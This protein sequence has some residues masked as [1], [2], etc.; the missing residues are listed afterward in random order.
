MRVTFDTN[1]YVSAFEFGGV[2]MKLLDM[3]KDGVLDVAVSPAILAET[4]RVLRGK[5]NWPESALENVKSILESYT[6][7]V[8]PT[9]AISAVQDDPD[10]NRILECAKASGS[11]AIITR[12][13]H[14][15]RLGRYEGIAM[16]TVA[17]FLRG[18][19]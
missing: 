8:T 2:C 9:E 17:D 11:D 15:L 7:M 1:I 18:Q 3:A 10:D 13:K 14:L 4:Q 12:D 19:V 5:F 6:Q 16:L